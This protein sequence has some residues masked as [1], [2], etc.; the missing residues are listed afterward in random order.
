MA[1]RQS[2]TLIYGAVGDT[3]PSHYSYAQQIITE[4]SGAGEVAGSLDGW[5][6]KHDYGGSAATGARQT[7]DITSTLTSPTSS[8]NV[9]RNYVALVAQANA[10]S[11][12]G[13]TDTSS[14]SKGAVFAGNLIARAQGGATNMRSICGLE[15]DVDIAT[16]TSTRTKFG[17][18]AVSWG[19]VNGTQHDAAF[20]V[21][22]ANG[23]ATS[24][25]TALLIGHSYWGNKAAL[26]T[27]G[28]VIAT[29]GAA[30]TIA[31]GID[32]SSLTITG[33]FLKGPGGFAVSGGGVINGNDAL[34]QYTL[35]A[36]GSLVKRA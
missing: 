17:V 15:V 9:N 19:S 29:D 14:N 8:S 13:G 24:W 16:G 34:S 33:N 1:L 28:A 4:D 27:D 26:T 5:S 32:L 20:A 35:L 18:A 2:Y 31:T 22:T 36:D 12:D 21:A 25:K 6:F 30:D 7:L 11:G 3:L 23:Q 10:Q